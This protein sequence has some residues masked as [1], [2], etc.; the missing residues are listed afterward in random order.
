MRFSM[1][2][3][4]L[5]KAADT[6]PVFLKWAYK[7][8]RKVYC[9]WCAQFIAAVWKI[10]K[11]KKKKKLVRCCQLSGLKLWLEKLPA[12]SGTM[13]QQNGYK[14]NGLA[15]QVDQ[16]GRVDSSEVQLARRFQI[17]VISYEEVFSMTPFLC[18]L[19][20]KPLPTK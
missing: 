14:L 16:K 6:L 9:I 10:K 1:Q 3:F 18:H 17:E 5:H 4:S 12:Y 15:R 8:E 19:R 2:L 20:H 11:K 13:A 7:D